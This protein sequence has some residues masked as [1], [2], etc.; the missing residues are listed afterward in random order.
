MSSITLST[1]GLFILF[2]FYCIASSV[3]GKYKNPK[4]KVFWT[5]GLVF[6][7][8]LSFFFI[9]LKRDLLEK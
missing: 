4:D 6:V 2:W 7:P 8:F 1:L 5:I 3:L 9:Y